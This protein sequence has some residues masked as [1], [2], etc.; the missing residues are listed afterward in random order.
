MHSTRSLRPRAPAR[1]ASRSSAPGATASGT[2][3]EAVRFPT[4]AAVRRTRAAAAR[5]GTRRAGRT[6]RVRAQR[7]ADT[8]SGR[9]S[10]KGMMGKDVENAAG[11]AHAPRR[12]PAHGAHGRNGSPP[13]MARPPRR[14]AWPPQRAAG[15]GPRRKTSPPRRIKDRERRQRGR[16][17]HDSAVRRCFPGISLATSGETRRD[18]AAVTR[19]VAKTGCAKIIRNSEMFDDAMLFLS[20]RLAA[21]HPKYLTIL[22]F[23]ALI[24]LI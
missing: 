6:S 15:I 3:P 23:C 19:Y 13:F 22:A 16:D 4:V 17:V 10:T 7:H 8:S 14:P 1:T 12:F 24:V 20:R 21:W 11:L 5:P 2:R 9:T 18:P